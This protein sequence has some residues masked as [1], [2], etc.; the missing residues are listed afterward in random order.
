MPNLLGCVGYKRVNLKIFPHYIAYVQM[1]E[2]IWILAI[3]HGHREP[4]YWI[5]R[6]RDISQGTPPDG[7]PEKSLG[8]S[9]GSGGP[10][11][12]S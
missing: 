2:T 6:K 10:P 5:D 7:G 11:S 3:A 12:A 4:D 9:G 1:G 8:G